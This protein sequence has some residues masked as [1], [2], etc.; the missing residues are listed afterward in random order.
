MNEGIIEII[1]RVA[2]FLMIGAVFYFLIFLPQQKKMKKHKE[3]NESLKKGDKVV[4]NSGI[5]GIFEKAADGYASITVAEGVVIQVVNSSIADVLKG[6][7]AAEKVAKF[8]QQ[9][10]D[11]DSGVSKKTAT[12]KASKK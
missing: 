10:E 12:K 1:A 8:K 6:D 9:N 11:S 4:T 3:M 2:P 5:V 7:K